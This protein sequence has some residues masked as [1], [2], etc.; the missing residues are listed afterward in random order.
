MPRRSVRQP[1]PHCGAFNTKRHS[2]LVLKKVTLHGVTPH[3][4]QRW[5]C[6]DC[7]RAFTPERPP[8]ETT[9][10]TLDVHEKAVMLYF[11]QGSAYRAVARELQRM[12][13]ARIT[14]EQCWKMVQALAGNCKAPWEVSLE[15][16]PRWSGFIGVDADHVQVASHW[17][18][19]MLGVDIGT[20]DIPHLILAEREDAETWLFYFLVLKAVGYPFRGIV[21]D[22]DP[23]IWSAAQLVC[24]GVPHQL[25]V[26][27]FLDDLHRY[28]RY[29]SSHGRGTW[30]ILERFENM[31]HGCLYALTLPE[32][33]M[34]LAMIQVDPDFRRIQLHDGIGMIER[35][36]T[37]LT[38]HFACPGLPRTNNVTEGTIRKLDRRLTPM[39]GFASHQS[40]WNV[41]KMLTLHTRFRRL[42]DCRQPH[43]HRNGHNPL[44]LAGID[45][46]QLH[47][48]RFG[49]K[50]RRTMEETAL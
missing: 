26:K 43:R 46:R 13:V 3:G 9:R 21:S 2:I 25:C 42:T 28:L 16:K 33:R 30:R 31:A 50:P 6:K 37:A 41:L 14:P 36:F 48:I 15:L 5:Y 11:D 35:N 39:D 4:V 10:Y 47:W 23:S 17:E 32:V 12:G 1:C 45:T 40:A 18:A 7:C 49:Q 19:P 38:Q 44:Q 29:R 20:L 22:G 27:H 34:R 8:S 24:P